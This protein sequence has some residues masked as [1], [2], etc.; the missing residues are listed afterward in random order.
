MSKKDKP[1]IPTAAQLET[2]LKRLRYRERFR[3]SLVSTVSSLILDYSGLELYDLACDLTVCF[4][5]AGM[6][7]MNYHDVA[8]QK[9]YREWFGILDGIY[10]APTEEGSGMA[11]WYDAPL[12]EDT[13]VYLFNLQEGVQIS[14]YA[15]S[16]SPDK[17]YRKPHAAPTPELRTPVVAETETAAVTEPPASSE[18]LPTDEVQSETKPVAADS[19]A[20]PESSTSLSSE[21][22]AETTAA[23]E[24]TQANET[25]NVVTETTEEMQPE[26][27]D[28]LNGLEF[29]GSAEAERRKMERYTISSEYRTEESGQP[30]ELIVEYEQVLFIERRCDAILCFTSLGLVGV[31]Y[32]DPSVSQYDNYRNRLTEQYGPP[33]KQQQDYC[34]WNSQTDGIAVY[35]FALED[36]IQISFFADDT[37]SELA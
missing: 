7:G 4:T 25:Q 36:G 17:S 12:G 1:D 9:G 16:D 30:W 19:V 34:V 33:D 11:A 13:A 22:A 31:S 18:S 20:V 37:G 35:V 29:Y 21:T 26:K 10:G 24:E 14:F 27:T 5:D 28:F 15:T 23:V 32:V 8:R 6:I 2:E 3:H